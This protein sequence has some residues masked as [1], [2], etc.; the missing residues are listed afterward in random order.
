MLPTLTQPEQAS[1]APGSQAQKVAGVAR[2]FE[3]TINSYTFS[4]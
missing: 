3:V 4:Y 1:A 2:D